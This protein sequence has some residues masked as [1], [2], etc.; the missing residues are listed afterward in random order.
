MDRL[1]VN[2]RNCNDL[3]FSLEN[4]EFFLKANDL[5][6][7][8]NLKHQASPSNI[9]STRR[10]HFKFLVIK[11]SMRNASVLLWC[12]GNHIQNSKNHQTPPLIFK[13]SSFQ[14]PKYQS[15]PLIK[16]DPSKANEGHYHPSANKP[17]MPQINFLSRYILLNDVV[18]QIFNSQC[19]SAAKNALIIA[20]K[21]LL[22]LKFA[23]QSSVTS[24]HK[25]KLIFLLFKSTKKTLKS[26]RCWN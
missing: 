15:P 21:K 7:K 20:L 14:I 11:Y 1:L 23:L 22:K 4:F 25:T 2:Y 10:L 9:I 12:S 17:T 3:I 6:Q 5:L 26:F 8:D 19:I 13:N 18:N 16:D 24:V